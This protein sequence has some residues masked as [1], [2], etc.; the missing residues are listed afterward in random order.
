MQAPA[1]EF[2]A[3]V[4]AAEGGTRRL[5]VGVRAGVTARIRRGAYVGAETWAIETAVER[6]RRVALAYLRSARG[7]VTFA[8][9]TAAVLLGIPLVQAPPDRPVIAVGVHGTSSD[10]GAI[11]R[12]IALGDAEVV[13][14]GG[15]TM[16]SPL[17][18]AIDVG[19]AGGPDAAVVAV[20]DVLRRWGVTLDSVHR[21]LARRGPFR[22]RRAIT[23]VLPV[24]SP[25]CESPLEGV[26]L[27][28]F[29]RL[30]FEL[31]E[32]QVRF[33]IDGR[34]YYPDYFW[35]SVRV[36]GEADGRAKYRN[37]EALWAEKVR[38]DALR[39]V[40]SGFLRVYWSDCDAPD[41]L[42]AKLVRVGVPR[43]R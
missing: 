22:G 6:H 41:R 7:R 42:R 2:A 40:T 24:V 17:R 3:D 39:S 14:V 4:R 21:A 23:A 12:A 37:P 10:A 9:E 30:G 35:R 36:V 26:A 32:L 33:R 20:N 31:P 8:G 28:R 15:I 29:A 43:A 13:R 19:A 38:E 11:R 16:T 27:A 34:T 25:R 18:T 1:T 5:Q